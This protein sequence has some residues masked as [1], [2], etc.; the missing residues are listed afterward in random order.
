MQL[1]YRDIPRETVRVKDRKRENITALADLSIPRLAGWTIVR[2][3]GR[4]DYHNYRIHWHAA[5][6]RARAIH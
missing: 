6:L 1:I 3:V 4:I 2:V 5:R